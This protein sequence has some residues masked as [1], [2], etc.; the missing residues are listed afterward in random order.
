MARDLVAAVPG[1][2]VWAWDRREE[3]PADRTGFSRSDPA[4][5]YV[6]GHYRSQYPAASAFAGTWGLA[7]TLDDLRAVVLAARAGGSRRVVLGGHSWGAT[8]AL[9]YAAWDFAGHPGFRD[10]AGLAVIDGGVLGAFDGTGTPVQDSPEEVRQQLAATT[11]GL[12]ST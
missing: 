12:C 1:V 2:Q 7:R 4:S 10:L 3:N 11:V 9:A 8:S 6:D 5:Y